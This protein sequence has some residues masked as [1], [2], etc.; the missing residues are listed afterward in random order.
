[1]RPPLPELDFEPTFAAAIRRAGARF[2]D[3][4]FIVLPDERLSFADVEVRS[5]QLAKRLVAAGV[6]K[7]T[8]VGLFFTYSTE[9]VVTWVAAMRIGALVMPFSSI[10]KPAELQTV[11][12]IGDVA[13]LLAAPSM[14]GKDMQVFLEEAVPG[15]AGAEGRELFLDE[16]PY[17]RRVWL[18]GSSDRAW[19]TEVGL[20]PDDPGGGVSDDLLER[21]EAE[22]VPADW[23][24]VTYTSGSSAEPKGVVHSHGAILR[25]TSPQAMAAAATTAALGDRTAIFCAF[26]FFW[27]GGTLVLGL[28]I[29][30][31]ATVCVVPRFEPGPAIELIA[32]EGCSAVMAWPSLVQSMRVHPSFADHDFSSILSLADPSTAA[33]AGSP[34][35]GTPW[36]RGMSETVGVWNGIERKVVDPETGAT[37]DDLVDG[38][39]WIRGWGA[40]QGY[41]K[42]ERE[43]TFDADG[44]LHTGDRV[45][46]YENRAFFVGRFYEMIKSQGANVSPREVEVLLESYPEVEHA[47]VFGLPHPELEEEVTAIIVP[48][49]GS[50]VDVAALQARA[51]KDVSSYKVPTRIEVWDDEDRIPWLGSGKPDKLAVR[52]LLLEP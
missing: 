6:G 2:G 19:A 18:T 38:E 50:V 32:R 16:L 3:D 34:R 11:L 15:L 20:G 45:F 21:I 51:R 35:P 47:L 4:D 31:G 41:Y 25:S 44:W 5:R 10:Y 24:Q 43:D 42:K 46:L 23:A 52:Q 17:L 48:T 12:R 37:M 26:P 28:A 13:L 1:M 39:L 22:V 30:S 40:L 8:R 27:I 36:H 49:P 9:F 7:G 33:V 14:L 29:Q